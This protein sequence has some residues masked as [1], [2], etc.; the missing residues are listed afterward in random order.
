MRR[1]ADT[2]RRAGPRPGRSCL[3]WGIA[4]LLWL[5]VLLHLFPVAW[6][7]SA[8]LKPTREIFEEPF[9]L[10]PHAAVGRLL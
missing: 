9:R 2:A 8:S 6:M 1:A 7:V 10:I 4:A 5:G 3:L